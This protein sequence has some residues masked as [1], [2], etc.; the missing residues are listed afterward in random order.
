[1][2]KVRSGGAT[3]WIHAG[4]SLA[5]GAASLLVLAVNWFDA[6]TAGAVAAAVAL[7]GLV[8]EAQHGDVSRRRVLHLAG[9]LMGLAAACAGQLAPGLLGLLAR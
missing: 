8:R 2:N 7:V 5:V 4:C 1:M 3:H 9:L 6:T